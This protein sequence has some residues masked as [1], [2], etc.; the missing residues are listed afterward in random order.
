MYWWWSD[1]RI[2]H[3]RPNPLQVQLS[4][5][6]GHVCVVSHASVCYLY[7]V[8][9]SYVCSLIFCQDVFHRNEQGSQVG[10]TTVT[11]WNTTMRHRDDVLKLTA[12]FYEFIYVVPVTC[13]QLESLLGECVL[14]FRGRIIC[15]M[16]KNRSGL[17]TGLLYVWCVSSARGLL[18]MLMLMIAF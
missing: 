16:A 4:G 7:D 18:D 13:V 17:K 8:C 12:Q 14:T 5:A 3:W 15:C 6:Y 2:I 10:T 1:R 11:T 9:M